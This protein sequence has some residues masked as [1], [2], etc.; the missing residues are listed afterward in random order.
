VARLR[1]DGGRTERVSARYLVGCDGAHS[2]VR[3]LAGIGFQ[4]GSYPQTFVLADLE[5]DGL[6]TDA[7]HV[8]LA[9]RGQLFFFPLGSPTT[10]R[11]L[12]MRPPRDPVPPGSQVSLGEVQA[13][14]TP[15]PTARSSFVTRRG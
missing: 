11:P 4:G 10:C 1:H 12:A 5:A 15:T 2:T 9:E 6:N 13:L 8:F 3:T 14:P 7:A